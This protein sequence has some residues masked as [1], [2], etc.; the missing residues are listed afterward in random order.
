[1][2]VIALVHNRMTCLRT[3]DGLSPP[4]EIVT[5][6]A[7]QAPRQRK[8]L[9]VGKDILRRH[10]M[11]RALDLLDLACGL[12]GHHAQP[13]VDVDWNSVGLSALLAD[14]LTCIGVFIPL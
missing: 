14:K 6:R 2:T 10:V 3:L 12:G 7:L 4:R 5:S 1:M 8:I 13:C 11:T 9:C